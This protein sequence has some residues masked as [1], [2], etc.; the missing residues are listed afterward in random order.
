[1][2]PVWPDIMIAGHK[3]LGP[4]QLAQHLQTKGSSRIGWISDPAT[5]ATALTPSPLPSNGPKVWVLAAP[6]THAAALECEEQMRQ[7][8]HDQQVA[9]QILHPID[10]DYFSAAQRAFNNGLTPAK[11]KG[12]WVCRE[13]SDPACEHRLFSQ[14]LE[15]RDQK[16]AP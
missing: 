9:H 15:S 8:L 2:T 12:Q 14:L 1:M 3:D 7:T 10:G 13:C 4:D 5:L 11:T 16:R 6:A